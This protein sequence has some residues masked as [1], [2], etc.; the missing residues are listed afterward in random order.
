MCTNT[1]HCVKLHPK[2]IITQT[3]IG[4]H[5]LSH[6]TILGFQVLLLMRK[7]VLLQ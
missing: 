7:E 4:K 3:T 2:N 5:F 1:G 6:D